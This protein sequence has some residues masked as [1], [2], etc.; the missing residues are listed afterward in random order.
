MMSFEQ[1][2]SDND[3][4]EV[5]KTAFDADLAVS[6]SW[7]YTQEL[8]TV[9]ESTE[10]PLAQLEHMLA[11]MRSY[12]EMNM[13]LPKEDRYGSINLNETQREQIKVGDLVYDKVTYE[14]TAMKEDL[15]TAFINEYK[16]GLGTEGFDITEHFNQRKKSHYKQK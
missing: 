12:I 2:K 4:K 13:T 8:A 7:G 5:I 10:V 14:I 9:I 3:L 11:S 6:G 1:L 15:Y 16:E